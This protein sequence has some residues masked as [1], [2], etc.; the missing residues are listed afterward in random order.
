LAFEYCSKLANINIP[1]SVTNIGDYAFFGCSSL[2]SI[3]IPDSVTNIGD[4]AFDDCSSL[5]SVTIG[6][7]V[8]NIEWNKF[9]GC[10]KITSLTLG[11]GVTKID[12]SSSLKSLENV[13]V[14]NM[15]CYRYFKD[16]IYDITF[17]GP[18]ASA[19]G[20]CLIF[21]GKLVIFLAKGM[22]EY[23]I[24]EG[25]TSIGNYALAIRSLT[26]VAIP[27]S[28][29][30]ISENAFEDANLTSVKVSN[31]YCYEY[32]KDK[33]SDIAFY[34]ANASAD[35][36]CLIKNGNLEIFIA[37][38][39]TKYT[40]PEGITSMGNYVF[41]ECQHLEGITCLATIP[42]VIDILDIAATT[43]I[44]VPKDAVKAYKNDPNWMKYKKQIKPIK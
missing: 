4:Y 43:I 17:W 34:G 14:A 35:G 10:K 2:T 33:I 11:T 22:T 20:R 29:T 16:K 42:P 15:Y 21:D 37:K 32:F 38:G 30:S 9:Y 41:S 18:N 31:K 44:Y 39:I 25:V 12:W 26:S 5:T 28:V 3:N 36:R 23:T 13:K 40:I 24:P 8:T 19:D 1:D 7:G 27:E 6:N